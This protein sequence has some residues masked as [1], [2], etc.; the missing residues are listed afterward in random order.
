[1]F[2]VSGSI[3]LSRLAIISSQSAPPFELGRSIAAFEPRADSRVLILDPSKPGGCV[4]F[5]ASPCRVNTVSPT[6][7]TLI[8]P[9][10]RLGGAAGSSRCEPAAIWS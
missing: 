6:W 7:R 5:F 1:M 10:T 8:E 2:F 4:E 9:D 3:Q